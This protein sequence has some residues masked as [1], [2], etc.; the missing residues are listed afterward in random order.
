[1]LVQKITFPF[2]DNMSVKILSCLQTKFED[3]ATSNF[4]RLLNDSDANLRSF[5]FSLEIAGISKLAARSDPQSST[6][7]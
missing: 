6:K 4:Y 1:M 3:R 2:K 7:S 5:S